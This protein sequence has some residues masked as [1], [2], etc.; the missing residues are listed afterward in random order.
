MIICTRNTRFIVKDYFYQI[1]LDTLINDT[2]KR[3][4][5]FFCKNLQILSPI[6]LEFHFQNRVF[7][8]VFLDYNNIFCFYCVVVFLFLIEKYFYMPDRFFLFLYVFLLFF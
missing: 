6:L 7:F 4:K 2:I 3:F 5:S 1:T 8:L